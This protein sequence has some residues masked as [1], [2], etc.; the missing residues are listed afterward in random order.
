M[1]SQGQPYPKTAIGALDDRVVARFI[2][3]IRKYNCEIYNICV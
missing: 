3:F 1:A 2:R